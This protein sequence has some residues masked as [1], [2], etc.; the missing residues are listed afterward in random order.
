MTQENKDAKY[1]T[2]SG[3]DKTNKEDFEGALKDFNKSLELNPNWALTYFSKAIVFHKQLKFEEAYENYSEAIN[4]DNNMIDAYYN[5]A[6]ILL[7]DEKHLNE[8]NLNKALGDLEQSIELDDKFVDAYYY[9]AVVKMK[10][11]KYADSVSVLD[12]LIR[13]EPDA[14]HAKALKKLLLQKYLK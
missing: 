7:A 6:H 11:K 2:N 9:L 5:R 8:I 4:K 10:L 14:I 1:Y 12:K 3:I 13:I